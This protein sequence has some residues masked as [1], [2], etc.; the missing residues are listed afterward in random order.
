M[1]Y[2]NE[3][4]HIITPGDRAMICANMRAIAHLDPHAKDKGSY[5][6]RS[7]YFDTLADKALREKND[8]VNI[9][10]SGQTVNIVLNEKDIMAYPPS[11][12]QEAEI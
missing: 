7:L 6:V 9:Y 5:T 2:R 3:I 10:E 4:K 12:E 1:Q 11:E 8:G